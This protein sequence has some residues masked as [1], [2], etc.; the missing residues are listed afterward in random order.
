M[1][2]KKK[3]IGSKSSK[4]HLTISKRIIK[5]HILR[6]VVHENYKYFLIV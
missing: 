6:I 3:I 1:N 5:R 2:L 4:Y